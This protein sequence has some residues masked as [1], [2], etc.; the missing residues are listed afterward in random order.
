MRL[1]PRRIIT[2]GR[3]E[4]IS[5]LETALRDRKWLTQVV[6]NKPGSLVQWVPLSGPYLFILSMAPSLS[7]GSKRRLFD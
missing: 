5:G 2:Q 6:E 4:P 1:L 3:V 7:L